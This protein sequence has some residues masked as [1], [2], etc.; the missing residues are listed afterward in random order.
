MKSYYSEGVLALVP[1]WRL[2]S[3]IVRQRTISRLLALA[4]ELGR[5]ELSGSIH[6]SV[7]SRVARKSKYQ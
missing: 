2:Q 7:G 6:L 1:E 3:W 4:H 5:S